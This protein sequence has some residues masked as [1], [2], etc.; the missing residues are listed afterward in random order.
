[1]QISDAQDPLIYF[2]KLPSRGDFVRS[3]RD[4]SLTQT[5]DRWISNSLE[6]LATAPDWKQHFDALPPVEFIVAGSRSSTILTGRMV[7]SRD[8]SG[9]RYPFLIARSVRSDTPLDVLSSLP[10]CLSP[11]WLA[12][13]QLIEAAQ[14]ANDIEDAL[15]RIDLARL[16][17]ETDLAA[18]GEQHAQFLQATTVGH[19]QQMLIASGNNAN[20]RQSII[21]LGLLLLPLLTSGPGGATK[22]LA[23]PLP[24]DPAAAMQIAAFWLEL[25]TPFLTRAGHEISLLRTQLAG[26][27]SLLLNLNGVSASSLQSV[28]NPSLAFESNIDL[29]EADWT[30]DYIAGEYPLNKLSSYLDH[31]DLSLA[32]ALTTFAE[33]FLGT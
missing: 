24:A 25:V 30:E 4:G 2:G 1:M 5:L 8:S 21:A 17:I 14:N 3:T 29:C 11:T 15:A 16:H 13:E 20:L 31:P 19:V 9:R 6:Q 22:G 10:L 33:V 7:A 27:P 12:M 23:L 32:Q 26:R 28:F 18:I